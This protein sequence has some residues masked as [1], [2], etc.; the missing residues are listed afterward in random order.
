M[1]LEKANF[2]G[3]D[4]WNCFSKPG[5]SHITHNAIWPL[6]DISEGNL[7]DYMHLEYSDVRNWWS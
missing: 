6:S 3:S 2:S 4:Q 7:S 5:I 1:E